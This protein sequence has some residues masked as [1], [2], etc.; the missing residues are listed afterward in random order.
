M[1]ARMDEI[2]QPTTE[3][4]YFLLEILLASSLQQEPKLYCVNILN[5]KISLISWFPIPKLRN[6]STMEVVLAGY[7]GLQF[8]NHGSLE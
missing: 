5:L 2:S 8:R 6:L 3:C 4:S 7:C 1:S